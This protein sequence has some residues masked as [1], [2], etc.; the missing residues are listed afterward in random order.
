[1]SS[2]SKYIGK[3]YKV[4]RNLNSSADQAIVLCHSTPE[5]HV[6]HPIPLPS[7]PHICRECKK[8][9]TTCVWTSAMQAVDGPLRVPDYHMQKAKITAKTILSILGISCTP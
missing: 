2:L 9:P 6:F 8:E 5:T 3:P 1:M 4:G 7:L